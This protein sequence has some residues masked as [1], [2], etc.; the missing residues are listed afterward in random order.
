MPESKQRGF[1]SRLKDRLAQAS[2]AEG[3]GSEVGPTAE[4]GAAEELTAGYDNSKEYKQYIQDGSRYFDA[5]LASYDKRTGA[6]GNENRV[7][8]IAHDGL[9]LEAREELKVWFKSAYAESRLGEGAI[10]PFSHYVTKNMDD[11]HIAPSD[12]LHTFRGHTQAEHIR[13]WYALGADF[14]AS[15]VDTPLLAYDLKHGEMEGLNTL[16]SLGVPTDFTVER[17]YFELPTDATHPPEERISLLRAAYEKQDAAAL[18]LLIRAKVP[19]PRSDATMETLS[20]SVCKDIER[21]ITR[22][23]QE[24]ENN[25]ESHLNLNNELRQR[26]NVLCLLA[27]HGYYQNNLRSKNLDALL[28][29]FDQRFSSEGLKQPENSTLYHELLK[30]Y[31]GDQAFLGN[32]AR[33]QQENDRLGNYDNRPNLR[34][35]QLLRNDEGEPTI[36]I[37][38]GK[39]K[40]TPDELLEERK[41]LDW[42]A[43][44]A[45]MEQ[46]SIGFEEAST[47]LMWEIAKQRGKI[48]ETTEGDM[49]KMVSKGIRKLPEY[50]V[51]VPELANQ[52]FEIPFKPILTWKIRST[53]MSTLDAEQKEFYRIGDT[54]AAMFY[55]SGNTRYF[56]MCVKGGKVDFNAENNLGESLMGQ[57]AAKQ[58]WNMLVR[59]VDKYGADI[60]CTNSKGQNLADIAMAERQSIVAGLN[61]QDI[62]DEQ[63]QT[64]KTKLNR[65]DIFCNEPLNRPDFKYRNLVTT[66]IALRGDEYIPD[67]PLKSNPFDSDFRREEGAKPSAQK[68]LEMRSAFLGYSPE[69]RANRPKTVEELLDG[70]PL[71]LS[72][73]DSDSQA[74]CRM[75]YDFIMD[76]SISKEERNQRQSKFV[77]ESVLRMTRDNRLADA[78]QLARSMMTEVGGYDNPKTS[79]L[80]MLYLRN[81]ATAGSQMVASSPKNDSGVLALSDMLYEIH[82]DASNAYLATGDAQMRQRYHDI[83]R[84]CDRHQQTLS[85]EISK[86]WG[87]E[88]GYTVGNNDR[89]FSSTIGNV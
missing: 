33:W 57:F 32:L 58:D 63:F 77:R 23:I 15:A 55:R 83:V 41:Q 40:K 3:A 59:A 51:L 6:Y 74:W 84:E 56:E 22:A 72:P 43:K 44:K 76:P 67:A 29:R 28:F 73:P 38:I 46:G 82:D 16:L 18:S 17:Q 24:A 61:T 36:N 54:M 78:V 2:Q 71:M 81:L 25:R 19:D 60:N 27:M 86:Y 37:G 1:F 39:A 11:M 13:D 26:V 9:D 4:Q 34:L 69:T 8:R 20:D 42:K 7:M 89:G 10:L 65:I 48:S 31:E 75:A 53:Y 30:R 12:L 52:R 85:L 47:Q 14:T 45:R 64:L 50:L 62:S 49:N 21:D 88:T 79:G 87:N 66:A 5:V 68:V 35:V 70:M 80:T